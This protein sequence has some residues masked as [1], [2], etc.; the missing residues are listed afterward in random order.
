MR[1]SRILPWI[2]PFL[3]IL[4]AAHAAAVP[5]L[6]AEF[7]GSVLLDGQPAP[8]GT[9]ISAQI[10]GL[11]RGSIT[12]DTPGFYGGPGLFDPRLKVNV[13]EEEYKPGEMTVVFLINGQQ[14]AQTAVFD[15]GSSRQFDISTGPGQTVVEPV[16]QTAP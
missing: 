7:Y 8:A 4:I 12:I 1:S 15:A 3:L 16:Q 9:V 6:P 10:H 11:D 14:A 2:V 13:S 5:P